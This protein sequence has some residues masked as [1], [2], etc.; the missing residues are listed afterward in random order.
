MKNPFDET[1]FK[2]LLGFSFILTASFVVLFFVGQYSS[3]LEQ[4][5]S[6]VLQKK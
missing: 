6:K 4:Q 1:F 3:T 2:F 5:E